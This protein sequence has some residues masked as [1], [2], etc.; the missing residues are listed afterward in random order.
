MELNAEIKKLEE[1]HETY[2]SQYKFSSPNGS[3]NAY[4]EW[5][6]HSMIV[7]DKYFNSND[8]SFLFFKSVQEENSRN[9]YGLH[10]NYNKIRSSYSVLIERLKNIN[11]NTNTMKSISKNVFIVHGHNENIK[12]KIARYIEKLGYNPII[13]NEQADGGKTIIQKFEDNVNDLCYGIVIYSGCDEGKS[14]S[15]DSENYRDRARQYERR[16]NN[17]KHYSNS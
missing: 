13:L 1:L 3:S 16:K 17:T 9:G 2:L 7:F 5:Y 12:E 14:K 11:N 4:H 15:S 10:D 6:D 8:E